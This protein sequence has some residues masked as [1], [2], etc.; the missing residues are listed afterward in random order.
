MP[1]LYKIAKIK[2]NTYT[3]VKVIGTFFVGNRP[4]LMQ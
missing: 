3:V 1:T 4:N 2:A